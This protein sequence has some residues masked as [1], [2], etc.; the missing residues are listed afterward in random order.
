MR[1]MKNDKKNKTNDIHFLFSS[2]KT[3]LLF[4]RT[5]SKRTSLLLTKS[6]LVS[7]PRLNVP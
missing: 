4:P 6:V 1:L 5:S 2:K 7:Y 3:P